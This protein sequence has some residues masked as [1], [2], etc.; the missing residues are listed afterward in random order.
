MKRLFLPLLFLAFFSCSPTE[1]NEEEELALLNE[2]LSLFN[3][4]F[5]DGNLTVLDSL[6]TDEYTHTNSSGKAF[7]KASWFNYLEKRSA[8]LASG[9]LVMTRYELQEKE[10]RLYGPSAIITGKIL[11]AGTTNGEPFERSLRISNFWVKENST[12]K[13]AGFHDTRIN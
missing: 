6:T 13:R 1:T 2:T 3:Q 4:A 5:R 9:E 7:P 10:V 11:T 12:W 8:Q